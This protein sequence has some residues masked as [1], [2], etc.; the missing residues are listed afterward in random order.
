M[1]KGARLGPEVARCLEMIHRTPNPKLF[2]GAHKERNPA[3]GGALQEGP[4]GETDA[5]VKRENHTVEYDG[6]TGG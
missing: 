2:G 5:S 4:I 6:P 3:V 1:S